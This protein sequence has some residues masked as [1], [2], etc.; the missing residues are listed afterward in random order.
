MGR[1]AGVGGGGGSSGWLWLRLLVRPVPL[2]CNKTYLGSLIIST[3]AATDWSSDT[4]PGG[5]WGVGA[6][7]TLMGY[8][9]G[10]G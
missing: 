10:G 8:K 5:V 9:G 3:C 4:A 2:R 1:Q 6:K 7:P